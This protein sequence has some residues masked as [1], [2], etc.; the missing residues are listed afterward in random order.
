VDLCAGEGVELAP[1]VGVHGDAVYA[2]GTGR[3]DGEEGL[4]LSGATL[5]GAAGAGL[6]LRGASAT[7]EGVTWG[8][9]ALDLLRVEC[10]AAEDPTGTEGAATAEECPA[11]APL[12]LDVEWDITL[13][14][15][16]VE[17]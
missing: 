2:R 5:R 6:V 3:W 15:V 7:L 8:D 17:L 16:A 1:G 11:R 14:E 4:W 9:N 10:D 13:S 12:L